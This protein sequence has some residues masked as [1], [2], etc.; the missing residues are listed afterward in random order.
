MP[1]YRASL[2]TLGAVQLLALTLACHGKGGGT[3]SSSTTAGRVI[4]KGPSN[5]SGW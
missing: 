4:A 3:D 1:L 2:Q 5:H